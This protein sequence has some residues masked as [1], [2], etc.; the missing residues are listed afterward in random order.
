VSKATPFPKRFLV[1]G[2]EW[3]VRFK[4]TIVDDSGDFC[5]GLTVPSKRKI[6]LEKEL[7][8]E[9]LEWVFWHEYMHAILYESGVVGNTGGI[10]ELVEEI[11]CDQFANAMTRDKTVTW[12]QNR[13][14]RKSK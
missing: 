5:R 7:E 2:A 3:K 6:I 8:G 1:Q 10:D 14:S 4:N 11:I 13:K 12:K 9:E